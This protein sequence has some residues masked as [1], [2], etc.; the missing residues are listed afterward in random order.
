MEH[1]FPKFEAE[2]FDDEML[3]TVTSWPNE[4]IDELLKDLT[5]AGVMSTVQRFVVKKGI[6]ALRGIS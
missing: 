6:V 5:Q 4:V 3:Y 1:L 2:S